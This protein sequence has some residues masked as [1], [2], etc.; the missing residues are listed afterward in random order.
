MLFLFPFVRNNKGI[1]LLPPNGFPQYQDVIN[2]LGAVKI[3]TLNYLYDYTTAPLTIL[4]QG[5]TS[6]MLAVD[7]SKLRR[8][9]ALSRPKMCPSYNAVF[10]K[11]ECMQN[12]PRYHVPRKLIAILNSC[13][14]HQPMSAPSEKETKELLAPHL[15]SFKSFADPKTLM[16]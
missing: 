3:V 7:K 2:F 13:L 14:S 10:N 11:F 1:P 6:Y 15:S 12:V 8:W 4:Y 5:L 16:I 9:D